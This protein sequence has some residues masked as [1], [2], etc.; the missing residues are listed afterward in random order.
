VPEPTYRMSRQENIGF[1]VETFMRMLAEMEKN[2]DRRRKEADRRR[3]ERERREQER[4]RKRA[5]E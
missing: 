5:E 3:E 4:E 1:S 2:R